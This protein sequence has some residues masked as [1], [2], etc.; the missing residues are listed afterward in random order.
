MMNPRLILVVGLSVALIFAYFTASAQPRP[1]DP[2]RFDN[3]GEQHIEGLEFIADNLD[4]ISENP[5]FSAAGI[6]RLTIEFLCYDKPNSKCESS[7]SRGALD[8]ILSVEMTDDEFLA[9]PAFTNR[10]ASYL[11]RLFEVF[12]AIGLGQPNFDQAVLKINTIEEE[13]LGERM[14]QRERAAILVATSVARSSAV[15]WASVANDPTNRWLGGPGSGN[16]PVPAGRINWGDVGKSDLKGAIGGFFG[17]L[18]GGGLAGGLAGAAG[19]AIGASAVEVVDQL[20][21]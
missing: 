12:D 13:A 4:S 14:N 11:A 8:G 17:G 5:V 19:G 6:Q 10:Q 20:L 16:D 1:G 7:A 18:F 3:V 2:S 21:D 15:Y 9:D